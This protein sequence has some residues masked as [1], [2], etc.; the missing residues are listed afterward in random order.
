MRRSSE[1][2]TWVATAKS[3]VE[4]AASFRHVPNER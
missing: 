2:Y 4:K 3:H 1:Q